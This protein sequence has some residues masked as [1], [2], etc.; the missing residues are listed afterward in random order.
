MGGG[1]RSIDRRRERLLADPNSRRESD[2]NHN[3]TRV[4]YQGQPC[5]RGHSG[6]RYVSGHCVECLRERQKI[7]MALLRKDPK[8]REHLL[9]QQTTATKRWQLKTQNDPNRKIDRY[10]RELIKYLFKHGSSPTALKLIGM[11]SLA[12]YKMY[13]SSKFLPGMSWTNYGRYT[14]N[15]CIDHII[16]TNS[17]DLR[18]KK[19]KAAAFHHTNT[20]P[21]WFGDN[22]RKSCQL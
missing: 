20:Q 18:D 3:R 12:D 16:P 21:L 22:S 17:F 8:R 10:A 6:E 1:K 7:R 2:I 19:Q 4:V 15:W 14:G 11:P 13:I 5:L 9:R